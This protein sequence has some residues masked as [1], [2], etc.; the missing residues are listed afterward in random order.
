MTFRELGE[1]RYL[2]VA[3][4]IRT[5]ILTGQYPAA[6]LLPSERQLYAEHHCG[7][8]TLRAALDVLRWEGLLLK[9]RGHHTRITPAVHRATVPL[10]VGAT[11]SARMPT[12]PEA[13]TLGSRPEVPLLEVGTSD[14]E[15]VRY[16]ADRVL[17]VVP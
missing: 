10:A 5:A 2:A 1:A 14:G 7:R 3:A 4:S 15:R 13:A 11:V 16:P 6:S 8:D 12:R 9:E 17:L